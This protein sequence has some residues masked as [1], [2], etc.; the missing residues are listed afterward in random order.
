MGKMAKSKSKYE[1]DHFL[2]NH[3]RKPNEDYTH[4]SLPNLPE[5]FAGSYA[6]N[7]NEYPKFLDLYY[8]S[9]FKNSNN[10]YLT[11][12]HLNFAPILIDLDFRFPPTKKNRQY[13]NTFIESFLNIYLNLVNEIIKVENNIEIFILEKK[14]P[15]Y[16]K[17]KKI[18]K[19]G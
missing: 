2:K 15:K 7:K 19:D 17:E 8:E 16:D 1:L 13:T 12:K 4:T 10:A 14:F 3:R 5:S 11:E 6:I 18:V 9:I